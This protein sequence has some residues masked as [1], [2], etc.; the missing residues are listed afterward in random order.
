M[1][2]IVFI[3]FLRASLVSKRECLECP[4]GDDV[5]SAE[6]GPAARTLVGRERRRMVAGSV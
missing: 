4:L 1:V 2:F 3:E 5:V 6:R